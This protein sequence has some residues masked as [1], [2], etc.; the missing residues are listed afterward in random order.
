MPRLYSVVHG[1][2][3]GLSIHWIEYSL[4][5]SLFFE[6]RIKSGPPPDQQLY[7]QPPADDA[8]SVGE[9]PSFFDL[10]KVP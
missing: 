6:V 9:D 5:T 1:I 8:I 10:G 3:I 2:Q 7:V 4:L